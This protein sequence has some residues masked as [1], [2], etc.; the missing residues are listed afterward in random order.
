MLITENGVEIPNFN[1]KSL[2]IRLRGIELT[3]KANAAAIDK[4]NIINHKLRMPY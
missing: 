4:I 2:N 1:S 3:T